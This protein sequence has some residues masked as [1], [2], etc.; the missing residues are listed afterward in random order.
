MFTYP[1]KVELTRKKLNIY[2]M[3]HSMNFWK[4]LRLDFSMCLIGLTM[5]KAI[6]DHELASANILLHERFFYGI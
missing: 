3:L 2:Y 5:I 4:H 6:I 1:G